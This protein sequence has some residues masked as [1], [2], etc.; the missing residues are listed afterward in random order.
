[1]SAARFPSASFPFIT[2]ALS[3][4]V[5]SATGCA[6]IPPYT[7]AKL[8]R[9]GTVQVLPSVTGHFSRFPD[10][11][12]FARD[13]LNATGRLPSYGGTVVYGIS[14]RHNLL[15]RYEYIPDTE[16]PVHHANVEFKTAVAPRRMAVSLG[17]G[18]YTFED[19]LHELAL[20]FYHTTSIRRDLHYTFVPRA[21]LYATLRDK[22]LAPVLFL[23]NSLAWEFADR[24][25]VA[26]QAGINPLMLLSG[27][28][29]INFGIA[30]G[31][32]F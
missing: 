17:Y 29:G 26:P 14:E 15:A 19:P 1:M 11:F 31:V 24:C 21:M 7:S 12:P 3:A 10:D 27:T 9:P 18:Q 2:A 13:G 28:L 6:G 20:G 23:N 16:R 30:A 25:F 5:L 32:S 8:A 22:T 4:F